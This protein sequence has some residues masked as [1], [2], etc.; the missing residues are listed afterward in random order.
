MG[1]R[2]KKSF[3]VG[4]GYVNRKLKDLE[5]SRLQHLE[6]GDKQRAKEVMKYMEGMII[7]CNHLGFETEGDFFLKRGVKR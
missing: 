7:A 4:I 2:D 3:G 6:N 5:K 1:Q